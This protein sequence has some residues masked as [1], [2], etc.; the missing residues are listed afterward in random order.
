MNLI[1]S[2][3]WSVVR[4]AR[5]DR[6]D[7]AEQA[8]EM[9]RYRADLLALHVPAPLALIAGAICGL[10]VFFVPV[11]VVGGSMLVINLTFNVGIV[12]LQ[13]LVRLFNLRLAPN[14]PA[15]AV[16]ARALPAARPTEVPPLPIEGTMD[17][18]GSNMLAVALVLFWPVAMLAIGAI[19]AAF[20]RSRRRRLSAELDRSPLEISILP[21]VI[22]F[23]ALTAGAGLL[24]G[25]GS[26]VAVGINVIF[27]WAG[28]LIWRWL[29]TAITWRFAPAAV[30]TQVNKRVEREKAYRKQ[31]RETG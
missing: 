18:G 6:E 24:V 21:E 14:N 2:I 11:L 3:Q 13:W 26:F 7:R 9:A 16:G 4:D 28:F 17:S 27:A 22:L 8:S 15:V 12:P 19:I 31:L 29:Q 25:V 20:Y 5:L 10:A 23:Y 1:Q 30:R